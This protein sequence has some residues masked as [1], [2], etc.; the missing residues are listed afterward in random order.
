MFLEQLI[1]YDKENI[2]DTSLKAI[3]PYLA[4]PEFNADFIKAKVSSTLYLI[5][6]QHFNLGE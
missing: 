4:D 2:P 5:S 3:R 6:E 1:N